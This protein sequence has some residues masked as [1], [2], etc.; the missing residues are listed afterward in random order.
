MLLLTVDLGN[1]QRCSIA[2]KGVEMTSA[3]DAAENERFICTTFSVSY[4][5]ISSFS[6][7]RTFG[8]WV[9]LLNFELTQT[10]WVQKFT[11]SVTGFM[12]YEDETGVEGS[13][14]IIS[15][16]KKK[17]KKEKNKRRGEQGCGRIINKC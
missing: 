1:S 8:L 2:L 6:I 3:G 12:F 10:L 17:R 7:R 5:P 11:F 4:L 14:R 15:N 13:E 9:V 16:R